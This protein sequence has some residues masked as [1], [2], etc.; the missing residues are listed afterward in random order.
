MTF[1]IRRK[2]FVLLA[3]LT[4]VVLT[5]VL[6]QVT[7]TLS[8]AILSKVRYD[9]GQTA[10]IFQRVQGLR[11]EN[12]LDAAYL[13]GENTTFKANV[14]LLDPATVYQAVSDMA[15]LTRADLLIVTDADGQLLAW[16]GDDTRFDEDLT[17]RESIARVL[18]GEERPDRGWPELWYTSDGLFQVAT[19]PVLLNYE[20]LIG[21]LTLGANLVQDD[22]ASGLKGASEID[23][24]FLAGSE[25]VDTT[26]QGL[27]ASEIAAFRQETAAL[28]DAVVTDLQPSTAF[29]GTFAGEEVFAFLSPLGFGELAYYVATARKSSE[30]RL[31]TEL[32]D[33]I[34]LTGLLSLLITVVLAL[35]LGRKLTQPILNLVGGMNQVKAGDLQV[36]LQ[37][38]TA[39]EIGLLTSTFNDMIGNLR[40]RL[41]LMKY[42]GSHTLDMIQQTDGGDVPLGG[43]RHELAVL[44]TDIRGFTPYSEKREPEEVITMLNRYL[45]FQAEIVQACEG[46][47]DKFVGDEMM[48]LFIGP[49]ALQNAVRCAQQIMRRV[50]QEQASDPAPIHIGVGI[51]CGPAILGNMGAQNRMD[52]TAIGATVNLGARLMQV[53]GPGQI[54]L[55]AILLAQ[56]ATPVRVCQREAMHFKGL[57]QAI[58]VAEIACDGARADDA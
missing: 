36:R 27:E 31:L 24:T 1:S 29:E 56:L 50:E 45:G 13:I 39:D 54:L 25:L 57:S 8:G 2:L 19:V 43:S 7:T 33:S 52:Y 44:F 41:Q 16:F 58:E 49:K 46:S 53:A 47:V 37:A 18:R 32:R 42:V 12:L 17:D 14:S 51:N 11:Y 21:T 15:L 28:I 10:R 48:A 3:G 5:G 4:T 35:G 34:Y 9:F 22:G 23:I 6:T 20:T 30:L 55:P 26:V 38:T 40:E